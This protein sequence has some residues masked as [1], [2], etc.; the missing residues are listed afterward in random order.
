MDLED[1]TLSKIGQA[2]KERNYT[3]SLKW[4]LRKLISEDKSR[5]VVPRNLRE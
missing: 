1:I 4:N 5:K 3:I 2:Q